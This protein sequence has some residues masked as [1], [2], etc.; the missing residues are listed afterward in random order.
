MKPGRRYL[1]RSSSRPSAHREYIASAHPEHIDGLGSLV[2]DGRRALGR[3]AR[4]YSGIAP[5]P[6]F[7]SAHS[8]A[9]ET[10]ASGSIKLAVSS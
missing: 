10:A 9:L 4:S 5:S 1:G 3:L 7:C 2:E 8:A 6:R